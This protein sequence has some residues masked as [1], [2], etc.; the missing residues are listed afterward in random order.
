MLPT[1]CLGDWYA[2]LLFTRSAR[3]IIC[4]S[5]RSLLPVFVEARDPTSFIPRFQERV[6]SGLRRMGTASDVVDC[7][8]R[9]MA[10]IRI[11]ATARSPRPGLAKRSGFTGPLHDRGASRY[12]PWEG[13]NRARGDALCASQLR[14]S[15]VGV[16]GAT[17]SCEFI[18]RP[19]VGIEREH[20]GRSGGAPFVAMVPPADLRDGNHLSAASRL[21]GARIRAV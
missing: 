15:E 20:H 6:L 16:F 10:Q 18:I 9:A 7:E 17:A 3:L 21:D 1:N 4:V 2:N 13:S 5:E 8:A 19:A 12:R 14:I 11:G